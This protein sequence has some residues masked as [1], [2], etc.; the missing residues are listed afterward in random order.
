MNY[1][2]KRAFSY[3]GILDFWGFLSIDQTTHK[4]PTSIVCRN[5][6]PNYQLDWSVALRFY[7]ECESIQY[8]N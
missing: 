5:P 6:V 8:R 1:L 3:S 2:E 7:F 4:P